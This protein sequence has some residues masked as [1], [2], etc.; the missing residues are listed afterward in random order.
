MNPTHFIDGRRVPSEGNATIDVIDPS[1]G[2]RFGQLARGTAGDIDA[3]VK[4]ARRAVGE[5]FDGPW[6]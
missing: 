3:A 1:D 2:E 5:N 6:G 4:A